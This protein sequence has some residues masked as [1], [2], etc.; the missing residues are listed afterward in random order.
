METVELAATVVLTQAVLR[1]RCTS[2]SQRL[3]AAA[4]P[5]SSDYRDRQ[6]VETEQSSD[7]RD[8]CRQLVETVELAATV[9]LV[10]TVRAA[11]V[12]Q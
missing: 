2:R 12:Q 9:E 4:L 8:M 5:Q 10:V 7:Y 6:L 3:Q 1:T 11:A